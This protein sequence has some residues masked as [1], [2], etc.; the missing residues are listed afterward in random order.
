MQ[1]LKGAKCKNELKW[2]DQRL[3]MRIITSPQRRCVRTLSAKAI[4]MTLLVYSLRGRRHHGSRGV[5]GARRRT[6]GTSCGLIEELV[7]A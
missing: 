4:W 2:I 5:S 3:T 7:K 6:G 1:D